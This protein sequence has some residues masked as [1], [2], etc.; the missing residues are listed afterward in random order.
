MGPCWAAAVARSRVAYLLWS[1]RQL[2]LRP[3]FSL[4]LRSLAKETLC[5][6]DTRVL[7]A[8]V[9]YG[10]GVADQIVL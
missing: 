5:S 8:V 10:N 3:S 2:S 6:E 9:S 4:L 1:S 7:L